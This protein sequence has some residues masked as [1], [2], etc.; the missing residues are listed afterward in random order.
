MHIVNSEN[1]I[2]FSTEFILGSVSS[3]SVRTNVVEGPVT[4]STTGE[5]LTDK[6]VQEHTTKRHNPDSRNEGT[7]NFCSTGTPSTSNKNAVRSGEKKAGA[8]RMKKLKTYFC[9]TPF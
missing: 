2:V 9:L 6:R 7:S 3:A 8:G 1:F 4:G 5:S